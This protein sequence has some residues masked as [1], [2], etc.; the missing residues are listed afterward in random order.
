M[1]T[2]IWSTSSRRVVFAAFVAVVAT[3][4]GC[5]SPETDVEEPTAVNEQACSDFAAAQNIVVRYQFDG[6]G[7]MTLEDFLVTEKAAQDRLDSIGLQAEGEVQARI[8]E[9]ASE[10]PIR[11]RELGTRYSVATAFDENSRRVA[12]ACEAEGFPIQVRALPK[13]PS[14]MN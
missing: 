11:S 13:I 8:G 14:S 6:K 10:L 4:T 7:T 9:L 1:T 5:G 3:I 2:T 12:R